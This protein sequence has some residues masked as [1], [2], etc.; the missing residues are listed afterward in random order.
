MSNDQNIAWL[1]TVESKCRV[2]ISET[3]LCEYV[4]GPVLHEIPAAD[5]YCSEVMLWQGR[6]VPV[7]QLPS[8]LRSNSASSQRVLGIGVVAYQ[9][10][11]GTHLSFVGLPLLDSPEK[12]RVAESQACSKPTD[13]D[14]LWDLPGLCLAYFSYQS[15]GIPIVNAASLCSKEFREHLTF[16]N[17]P[18]YAID[19]SLAG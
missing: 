8:L 9:L 4:A 12:I 2:A 5:N 13:I 1:L 11:R 19:Q 14:P 3:E 18:S 7:I 16:L 17:E 15:A 10:S 6:P